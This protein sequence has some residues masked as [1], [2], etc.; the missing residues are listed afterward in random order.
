[1]SKFT[2]FVFKLSLCF[3]IL[4]FSGCV[5][6]MLPTSETQLIQ[7]SVDGG[8]KIELEMNYVDV[9]ANLKRAY[10]KCVA[11]RSHIPNDTSYIVINSQLERDKHQATIEAKANYGTYVSK[12]N[13]KEIQDGKTLLTL[14]LSKSKLLTANKNADLSQKRFAQEQL[15]ALGKDSKCN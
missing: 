11:Y 14:Y 8:H 7:Q 1:M 15:R 12:V 10:D 2:K 5:R 3:S 13:L 6:M 9:Y 4:V